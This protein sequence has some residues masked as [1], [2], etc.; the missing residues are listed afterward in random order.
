MTF[1]RQRRNGYLT[2][3]RYTRMYTADGL[4]AP[5]VKRPIG[6]A[7]F[8]LAAVACGLLIPLLLMLDLRTDP[9]IAE[10]WTTHIEAGWERVVGTLTSWIPFSVME[11]FI[12]CLVG[13]GIFFYVRLIINLG[14]ARFKRI[15]IG[16]LSIG[17]GV[18]YM[19]N[20]YVVSMAFAYYRAEMPIPQSQTKYDA[21]SVK[22]V[23][24]Y[25]LSDYNELAERL[26]RDENG[27]VECPYTFAELAERVKVEYARLTDP[28][29]N[30]YT[31]TA[32]PIVNS[33]FMSQM[34]ITGMTFLPTGEASVNN[35]AP[36]TT[37]TI[38]LAHEL[39][40]AKGVFRE[41]DA[42]LLARYVLISSDD[43]Y[44]RYCG[45]Y[46]AFDNL[47]EAFVLTEDIESYREFLGRISDKV[48]V[49]R[50][51]ASDY[52]NSQWDIIGQ[53]AEFFN[54]WYL[55]S[56]GATNGTG[57]YENGNQST[58]VT[59]TDPITGEPERDPETQQPVRI[60]YFSQVQK[61]FFAVYEQRTEE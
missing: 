6:K 2:P 34:L 42:N 44:L 35:A 5:I 54:N 36:P 19:L 28:Y 4:R 37:R 1:E 51:Y 21:E 29:F 49:E 32:K 30:Q 31:P 52:W 12:V 38:T 3:K 59:P 26:P 20:L 55:E 40:H 53:I 27:C 7:A 50:W 60:I 39:A 41:G 22:P 13:L 18:I 57:S 11:F 33:W 23:I 24:E 48:R 46:Y 25:F 8:I 56:N 43:D 45:Y 15:L 47:L 10:W 58:V 14:R 9:Q 61:M 17:V 16:A